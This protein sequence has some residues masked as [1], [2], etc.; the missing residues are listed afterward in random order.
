MKRLLPQ[1]GLTYLSVLAVVFY[2]GELFAVVLGVMALVLSVVFILVKRCRKTIYLPVVSAMVLLSCLV[3]VFYTDFVYEKTVQKYNG[4]EGEVCAKLLEEPLSYPSSTLYRF[5]A[6]EFEGEKCNF[7]FTVIVDEKFD[8]EPFEKIRMKVCFEE[9]LNNNDKTNGYFLKTVSYEPIKNYTIYKNEHRSLYYHAIK[10]RSKIR[11]VMNTNLSE[12]TADL[13]NALLIGDKYAISVDIKEDFVRTG[14]SHLI[15][16]S[17]FHFSVLASGFYLFVRK[18]RAKKIFAIIPAFIFIVIYMLVT[19]CTPSVLRSAIMMLLC[20]LGMLISRDT[21]SLNSLSLAAIIVLLIYGPYSAGNLSLM[22]SFACT[23]SII[24]LYPKLKYKF[25][26]RIINKLKEP[27]NRIGKYCRKLLSAIVSTVCV[28]IS[29]FVA[30][31][32]FSVIFF[33]GFSSVGV[34]STLLLSWP[35]QCLLVLLLVFGVCS[36]VPV[37]SLILP[38]LAYPVE[39]LSSLI[40]SFVKL[41]SSLE[42]SYVLVKESYIYLQIILSYLLFAL[43]CFNKSKYRFR[44]TVMLVIL[45]FVCGELSFVLLSS[46]KTEQVAFYDVGDGI[47]VVYRDKDVDAILSLDCNGEGVMHV[48]ED[49][50]RYATDVDFYA[51]T[52]NTFSAM[53]SLNSFAQSFAIDD[54]LLYDNKRTIE[55]LE[56][57]GNV[58]KPGKTYS[59]VLSEN[60]VADYYYF[61]ERY[62]IYLKAYDETMLVLPYLF[63]AEFLPEN[64]RCADYIVTNGAVVNFELL[65]CDTLVVSADEDK[66]KNILK[67]MHGIFN[68]AYLTSDGDVRISL[69]V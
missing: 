38:V 44:L 22:L 42:F 13:C 4:A 52:S 21:N 66:S 69:G 9:T 62:V 47:A 45:A 27:V 28:T 26:I 63:D 68:K 25:H 57:V 17:G 34:V 35:V 23:L 15:V 12:D 49:M 19:G 33:G 55:V 5:K 40:L 61:D 65:S 16:V 31:L 48:V 7:K 2:F 56:T 59:V 39:I 51:C 64:M 14:A 24:L 20:F 41:L 46:H 54:V 6:E 50:E 29:A 32:P 37:L 67:Y 10:L 1:I 36:F 3:F 58:H 43:M 18:F 53:R 8:I 60:V 11:D 30:S